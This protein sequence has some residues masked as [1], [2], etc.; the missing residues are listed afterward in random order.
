MIENPWL[1]LAESRIE[2]LTRRCKEEG[3]RGS[4]EGAI[5]LNEV[6]YLLNGSKI[7]IQKLMIENHQLKEKLQKK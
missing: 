6:S 7:E 3:M 5:D 2:N 1:K 4:Y